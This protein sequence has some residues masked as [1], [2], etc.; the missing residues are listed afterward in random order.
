MQKSPCVY[1]LASS[2]NGTLYIG[3]TSDLSGRVS[4]HVQELVPGF[5]A[6][7]RVHHLV[8]YETHETMDA[9]I[10][11]EKRLKKWNRLW[12]IRL[13]EQANPEWVDLFDR[14]SGEIA[15]LPADATRNR[16]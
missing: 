2:R 3:V 11:R 8:Y 12:K 14:D 13:I 9:A 1:I 7:Y 4:I 16:S 10:A 6:K 5:T 15:E